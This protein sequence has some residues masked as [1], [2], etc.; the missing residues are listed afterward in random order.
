MFIH[1]L[2]SNEALSSSIITV[3]CICWLPA[4][5][6]F[7]PPGHQKLQSNDDDDDGRRD[8][9]DSDGGDEVT[10]LN[11]GVPAG[12]DL[13]TL[14]PQ[15]VIPESSY[16]LSCANYILQVDNTCLYASS[17]LQCSHSKSLGTDFVKIDFL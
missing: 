11:T 16:P 13:G 7:P 5:P 17:S 15:L 12:S 2:K 10:L 6:K 9:G 14:V 1:Q 8:G 3:D 4:E